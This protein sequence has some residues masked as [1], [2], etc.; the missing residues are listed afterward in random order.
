MK[1]LLLP[2]LLLS[3]QAV[4]S[5]Q[6]SLNKELDQFC[7]NSVN[8]FHTIPGERKKILDDIAV[9]MAKKKHILFTCQTNSRRTVLLQTWAQTSFYYFGLWDKSAFSIGDTVTDVYP[10]VVNVLRESGFYYNDLSNSDSKGYIV[11]ISQWYENIIVSKNNLGTIDTAK[12]LVV[13]ICFSGERSSIAETT[14]HLDLPYKSPKEFENTVREPEKYAELNK[15]I[16]IEMLYL[17][18]KMHELVSKSK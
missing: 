10:E 9:Q 14:S 1:K 15:Q 2:L 11:Y 12:V 6:I 5:Q 18:S 7:K 13:S 17:A 4:Y 16:S 8:E 3:L